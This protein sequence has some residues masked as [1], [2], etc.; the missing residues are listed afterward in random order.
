[1]TRFATLACLLL[2]LL[3]AA[4][5]AAGRA[6]TARGARRPD[7][8]R[9]A[10]RGRARGRPRHGRARSTSSAPTRRGCRP[11]WRSSTPRRRCWTGFGASG[12]LTTTVYAETPPDAGGVV[13]GDLY[14]RGGGDPN[15]DVIDLG[16][17]AEQVDE[18][19][20]TGG[21]GPRDRRRVRLGHAARRPLRRASRSRRTSA[22]LSAL[23]ANRGRTGKRAP[24]WQPRP[25]EVQRQRLRQAAAPPRRGRARLD[26]AA[27]ARRRT[28]SRSPPGA[29][30]PCARCIRQMNPPVGQLHGRDVHQGDRGRR[31][32]ARLDRGGRRRD[33]GDAAARS[34]RS[35]RR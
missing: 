30:R 25:G 28:R 31:R 9:G 19:G 14:L 11:R 18:A 7:G 33:R 17:L 29:R 32:R 15:L 12:R 34:S 20:I 3:P 10:V 16:G 8:E 22:C 13:D 21:H 23:I 24:Y 35:S 4:A 26:A 1:M 2:L 6:G 5:D 27:G